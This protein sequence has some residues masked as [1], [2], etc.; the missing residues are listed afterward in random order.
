MKDSHA[1]LA[2]LAILLVV[3][4]ISFTK[5]TVEPYDQNLTGEEKYAFMIE[6]FISGGPP[7]DGIPSIDN[8][9]YLSAD[10]ANLTD[11]DKVFGINYLGFVAAYPQDILYWHEIVNEN[12]QG[13]KISITY[14]PLT[15]SII[16]YKGFELGISGELYN[17]NLVM[18]DRQTDARIPQI[19][20]KAVESEIKGK[21]LEKFPVEVTTW[22]SWL[23]KH[24]DTQVLS[25]D[26]GFDN[27]D[28]DKNPY[29]GYDNMLRVWFPLVAE[30][31]QLGTKEIVFG[32]SNK[33]QYVAILKKDFQINHP[34]GLD[35]ELAGQ[36][37]KVT[38]NKELGTLE[39]N[40]E[41]IIG[42][43]VY[44]FAWYA[45]HPDTQLVK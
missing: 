18:Y 19:L 31:D 6:N 1:I 26:T 11:K 9:K 14:C 45:Y 3:G 22:S 20:G 2:I 40:S 4:V 28:Y 24:P 35:V 10:E 25:R 33:D 15:E 13:E 30:S 36:K 17:S 43:E 44:W 29:P 37:L 38:Y 27:R 5:P 8:P 7:K 12:V 32:L 16:G 39:T 42:F 23:A 34:N 41:E 21:E